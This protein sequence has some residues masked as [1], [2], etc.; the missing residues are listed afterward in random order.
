[1]PSVNVFVGLD[2]MRVAAL[3]VH[4]KWL[5]SGHH[6][7]IDVVRSRLSRLLIGSLGLFLVGDSGSALTMP[8]MALSLPEE[9]KFERR[10]S[11]SDEEPRFHFD[12]QPIGSATR[13]YPILEAVRE[14][15]YFEGVA[16][17]GNWRD[18]LNVTLPMVYA[19]VEFSEN[20]WGKIVS[21]LR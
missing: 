15:E 3:S 19:P 5:V 11:R 10:I 4:K 7:A 6:S 18:R 20:D 21:R 16:D 14:L 17:R 9:E 12:V 1:M 13:R 8:F 2:S